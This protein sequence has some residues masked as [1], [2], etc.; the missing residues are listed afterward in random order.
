MAALPFQAHANYGTWSIDFGLFTLHKIKG[1]QL[2]NVFRHFRYANMF[3]SMPIK[4][5][6][7]N[8]NK[9]FFLLILVR[10]WVE[11]FLQF[12]DLNLYYGLVL[13]FFPNQQLSIEVKGIFQK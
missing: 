9:M 10:P 4:S 5:F 8:N 6:K 11:F 1:S 12:I 13:H 7:L 2:S 3:V